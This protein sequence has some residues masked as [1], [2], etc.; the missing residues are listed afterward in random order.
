MLIG[1][2][3]YIFFKDQIPYLIRLFQIY[4]M[5]LHSFWMQVILIKNKFIQFGFS[6]SYNISHVSDGILVIPILKIV[7]FI[8]NQ[9]INLIFLRYKIN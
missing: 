6:G 9:S 3:V 4:S 1:T 8:V 2:I 5:F 7:G